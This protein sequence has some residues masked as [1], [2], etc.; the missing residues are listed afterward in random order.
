MK[1]PSIKLE[2]EKPAWSPKPGDMLGDG[3][4]IAIDQEQIHG[5]ILVRGRLVDVHY[6]SAHGRY[7]VLSR[8]TWCGLPSATS[9]VTPR[10]SMIIRI[11]P[12]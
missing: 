9:L 11:D 2:H 4:V 3:M 7:E 12:C 1:Y 5:V 6:N 10:H 8:D